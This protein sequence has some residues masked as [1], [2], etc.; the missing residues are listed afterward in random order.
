MGVC[1]LST[2]DSLWIE[3]VFVQVSTIMTATKI[4]FATELAML[5]EVSV[6]TRDPDDR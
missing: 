2:I 1:I 5:A 3:Y 4:I 6:T